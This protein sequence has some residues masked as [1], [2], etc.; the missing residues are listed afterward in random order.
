M[1]LN[2][3]DCIK[4]RKPS[5]AAFQHKLNEG[6]ATIA[7]KHGLGYSLNGEPQKMPFVAEPRMMADLRS[8]LKVK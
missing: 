3:D 6:N 4:A 1:A 2:M 8:D 7:Q 5:V